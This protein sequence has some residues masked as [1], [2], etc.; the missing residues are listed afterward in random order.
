MIM[1]RFLVV[2]FIFF[3]FV[4]AAHAAQSFPA[5]IQG[6]Q[7]R[8][9]HILQQQEE[10]RREQ[11]HEL[12]RRRDAPPV[13]QQPQTLPQEKQD[14]AAPCMDV[15]NILVRGATVFSASQIADLTVPYENQCL[16][17]A[18][19]TNLL[20]AITNA[21]IEQGYI[22]SRAFA[23][24]TQEEAGVL[25]IM[26]IEGRV[27]DIIFNEGDRDMYYRGYMSFPSIKG[28]VLNLRDIEQ[29][30]DQMNRLPSGNATI[31][32]LPGESAGAERKSWFGTLRR[33]HGGSGSAWTI[34]G[35]GLPASINIPLL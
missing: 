18:G 35:R 10:R 23:D 20:R 32:L 15:K 13:G 3:A 22:T 9:D 24:P 27:E 30:I 7:H 4:F 33:K 31:E 1:C 14:P 25:R 8:Q 2:L 34:M 17:L 19:I 11:E 21:Y 6:Y 16:S 12:E 5:P 29:G 28:K 26:V